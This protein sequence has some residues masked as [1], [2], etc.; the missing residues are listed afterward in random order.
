MLT[1]VAGEV[2]LVGTGD[3]IMGISEGLV[4]T[5]FYRHSNMWGKT[6]YF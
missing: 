4:L 1:S 3:K 5:R 2:T 6:S